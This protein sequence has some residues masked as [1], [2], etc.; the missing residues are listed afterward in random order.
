MN[1]QE[2][3][4]YIKQVR[5]EANIDMERYVGSMKEEFSSQLSAVAEMVASNTETLQSHTEMIG[6]LMEDVS[7]LKQ[8]VSILKEDMVEV[9]SD[10]VEIKKDLKNK[11]DTTDFI[12]FKNQVSLV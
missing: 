5:N 4:K 2:I 9:K 12:N 6:S 3:Q 10:L 11:V 8:D 7:V 1:D